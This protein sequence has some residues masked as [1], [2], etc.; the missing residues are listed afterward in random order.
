MNGT[1][2]ASRAGVTVEAVPMTFMH[3]DGHVVTLHGD[4]FMTAGSQRRLGLTE[5]HHGKQHGKHFVARRV[6]SFSE[7]EQECIEELGLARCP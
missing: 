2:G 1:R 6:A 4:D 5:P 3:K 7:G